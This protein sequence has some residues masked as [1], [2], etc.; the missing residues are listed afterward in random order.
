MRKTK[1]AL[2]EYLLKNVQNA[3]LVNKLLVTMVSR[4]Q[5]ALIPA[6]NSTSQ[7]RK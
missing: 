4:G 1:N 2:L 5:I 7:S 6:T 3:D